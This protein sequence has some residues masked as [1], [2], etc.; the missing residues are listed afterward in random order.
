MDDFGDKFV[1]YPDSGDKTS[2]CIGVC[3]FSVPHSVVPVSLKASVIGPVEGADSLLLV[4]FPLPFVSFVVIVIQDTSSFPFVCLPFPH[5]AVFGTIIKGSI[6]ITHSVYDFSYIPIP[7]FV[8][9]CIGIPFTW[10]GR[11]CFRL[12]FR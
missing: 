6:A 4:C 12:G 7:V 8:S 5:I 3:T 2:V 10:T 1:V 11:L 9:D